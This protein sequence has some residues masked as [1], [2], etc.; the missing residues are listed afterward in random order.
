MAKY[1]INLPQLSGNLFLTDGGFE[2]TLVFHEGLEL[3]E[4]AA[5][6]QLKTE[7]GRKAMNNYFDRY[8]RIAT[9]NGL[10]FVLEAPTWRA[11]PDWAAKIGYS[12]K[13]L[14]KVNRDAIV[15]MEHIRERHETMY[16]KMPISGSIG[17][18]DDGYKP[19]SFMSMEEAKKY[20]QT[21]INTFKETAADF[22]TSFTICYVEEAIGIARAAKNAEMPVVIGFTVETDGNLPSGQT[23]KEAIEQVDR[24]TKEIPIYYMIN[25]AHPTHFMNVLTGDNWLSRIHAIRANSSKMS[26]KELDNAEELD[27]G[28]PQELGEEYLTL[29]SKLPNLNI[30]GGCCGTDHRHVESICRAIC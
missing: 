5:F 21:Q 3:P 24:E 27:E 23:L 22:I 14:D 10:G 30:L 12:P 20:H 16:S 4:F 6:T 7:E 8:A 25:C 1:R 17:P 18:Q 19:S 26:H 13:E 9:S 2:T 11:N 29:R 15:F 28:N